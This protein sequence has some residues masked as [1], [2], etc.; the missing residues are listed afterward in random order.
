MST[1]QSKQQIT[2]VKKTGGSKTAVKKRLIKETP[3][4]RTIFTTYKSDCPG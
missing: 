4:K 3:V 2:S 1:S